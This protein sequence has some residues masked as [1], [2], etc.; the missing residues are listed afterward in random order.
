MVRGG[1]YHLLVL[2]TAGAVQCWIGENRQ[3]RYDAVETFTNCLSN[4]TGNYCVDECVP[5]EAP[6]GHPLAVPAAVS[7]K[8]VKDIACGAYHNIVRF[9]DDSIACWGLNS[10]G[11][12][13]VPTT[14]ANGTHAKRKKIVGLHAGYSTT[15]VTF[16][17]GTVLCWGDPA[18]ADVVNGWTD[19][20]MSP[21][22]QEIGGGMGHSDIDNYDPA[23]PAYARPRYA[24]AYATSADLV[25]WNLQSDSQFYWHTKSANAHCVPFFDLGVETDPFVPLEWN[26]EQDG[27]QELAASGTVSPFW[28][29]GFDSVACDVEC[30]LD[31]TSDA[32]RDILAAKWRNRVFQAG[33]GASNPYGY[34]GDAP[35]RSCCDLQIKTDYAVAMRRTGQVISTR[36]TNKHST[37][38]TGYTDGRSNCRDCSADNHQSI[39]TSTMPNWRAN[40]PPNVGDLCTGA[41]TLCACCSAGTN[42]TFLGCPDCS[43]TSCVENARFGIIGPEEVC[44]NGGGWHEGTGCM[45]SNGRTEFFYWNPNWAGP[46]NALTNRWTAGVQ[47]RPTASG[48][49]IPAAN[50]E[51]EQAYGWST[52]G[53]LDDIDDPRVAGVN[54][55]TS[56]HPP[57]DTCT[58]I[59]KGSGHSG[60]PISP[61]GSPSWNYPPQM[62]AQGIVA[63]TDTTVWVQM[64]AS[65]DDAAFQGEC[66]GCAQ[67]SAQSLCAHLLW[68]QDMPNGG[69]LTYSCIYSGSIYNGAG[70]SRDKYGFINHYRGGVNGQRQVCDSGPSM[71]VA[72]NRRDASKP[73]GPYHIFID[74]SIGS[75]KNYLYP[76]CHCCPSGQGPQQGP[77]GVALISEHM[78]GVYT[79]ATG[80]DPVLGTYK[81][82]PYEANM[83]CQP[84]PI[85]GDSYQVC[86]AK[87]AHVAEGGLGPSEHCA[88][89]CAYHPARSVA[90]T[91]MAFAM[92][93][94]DH[95]AYDGSGNQLT[96]PGRCGAFP[97]VEAVSYAPYEDESQFVP[98]NGSSPIVRNDVVLHI[99]GSLW[100][101]CPPWPRVCSCSSLSTILSCTVESDYTSPCDA[102]HPE[103][104]DATDGG[105]LKYPHWTK[106]P[107]SNT[108]RS[109]ARGQWVSGTW[110]AITGAGAGNETAGPNT[111]YCP[112]CSTWQQAWTLSTPQS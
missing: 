81:G 69:E 90:S 104:E 45:G 85:N 7:A 107:A 96:P 34:P 51:Y 46:G 84:D 15:A 110:T 38:P 3:T 83:H 49:P 88:T 32:W 68:Q 111:R 66:S 71:Y 70:V 26:P 31:D 1:W 56:N 50:A 30:A 35:T 25:T 55:C 74:N 58:Q 105:A 57:T 92:I 95:R 13:N 48:G 86:E 61:S 47:V 77:S 73:W 29:N 94:A 21:V 78:S 18:V 40:C 19:L 44:D 79:L 52:F 109:P 62:F 102:G 22:N 72:L 39:G 89:F 112:D 11:Q 24:A 36:A 23:N 108:T 93:R 14:L 103:G 28:N 97:P 41:Y 64:S 42:P 2:D 98:C 65:L 43:A 9:T 63:G 37:C 99:W 87:C 80:L 5:V 75:D 20:M 100:D 27:A 33:Q 60:A 10:M 12:C 6:A 16:N 17:D 101:P 67:Q 59:C 54:N 82:M 8:T 106:V 91:R 76:T 53:T 4:G